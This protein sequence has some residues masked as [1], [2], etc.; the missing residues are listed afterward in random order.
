[1]AIRNRMPQLT[2]II[3][4]ININM[5]YCS[6]CNNQLG[7]FTRKHEHKTDDNI[8]D[9]W[10]HDCHIKYN[11]EI[12]EERN[13]GVNECRKAVEQLKLEEKFVAKVIKAQAVLKP[14]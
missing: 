7:I 2:N 14:F 5:K 8:I 3:N 10:C 1:M 6:L 11:K 9:I 4:N 13:R 12:M